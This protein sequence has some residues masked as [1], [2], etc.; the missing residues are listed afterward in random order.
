LK[1]VDLPNGDYIDYLVDG[2]NR[3]VTKKKNGSVDKR[4]VYRD[5]LHPVAELNANGTIAKRCVYTSGKNVPDFMIQGSNTF[6]I[7]SDQ[8]GSPRLIVNTA[9]GA[10]VQQ[11]QHDEF[12][13]VLT[14]T[15]PGLTP[16]GFGGGLYDADTGLV[17]FGVRDYDPVVGRWISKD[18]IRFD[19]GQANLY[20]YVNND[21][22][23][24]TDA[25]G[26][27]PFDFASC[28]AHG[29]SLDWCL[30]NEHRDFCSGPLGFLCNLPPLPNFPGMDHVGMCVAPNDNDCDEQ[31][32]IDTATCDG[33]FRRRGAAAARR[34]SKSAAERYGNCL[35]GRPIGPLDTWN[36]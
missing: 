13:N 31:F 22:V 30:E 23:N 17:R 36:N 28:L 18:P 14:D 6:R 16:F 20:V 26:T 3:R 21:P 25:F 11:M 9:T 4:W 1:H 12:G 19:G 2:Q 33:I 24:D 32:A 5:Q 15:N 10:I 8:L 29:Y 27:G 34:C 35:A 7:L